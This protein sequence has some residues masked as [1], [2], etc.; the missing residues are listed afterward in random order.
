MEEVS[1]R[2]QPLSLSPPAV[3]TGNTT[4]ETATMPSPLLTGQVAQDKVIEV[5]TL[6]I[7][8]FVG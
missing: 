8:T 3:P 4:S 5:L 2:L 7:I 1:K 6:S